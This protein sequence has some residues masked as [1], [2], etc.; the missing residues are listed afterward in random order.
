M[1]YLAMVEEMKLKLELK[2]KL[3]SCLDASKRETVEL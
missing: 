3:K 1:K 2:L